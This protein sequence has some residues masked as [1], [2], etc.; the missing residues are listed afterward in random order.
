MKKFLKFKQFIL[1]VA[2]LL[3][4]I[5]LL[6]L[7]FEK[8]DSIT[9]QFISNNVFNSQ[10]T[11]EIRLIIQDQLIKNNVK[12]L[13]KK[14]QIDII[15]NN[16]NAKKFN[17]LLINEFK[18]AKKIKLGY[19]YKFNDSK[20]LFLIISNY[21]CLIDYLEGGIL[22]AKNLGIKNSVLEIAGVN[23][24]PYSY[25]NGY[26]ALEEELK[27]LKKKLSVAEKDFDYLIQ[28]MKDDK[29]LIYTHSF[30]YKFNFKTKILLLVY[31][32]NV[33][34]YILLNL[35]NIKKISKS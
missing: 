5:L 7:F 33:L 31:F 15:E 29:F 16:F 20:N 26:L 11:F 12:F 1:I 10:T 22:L 32:I 30:Y 28:L 34:L 8:K 21:Q 3:S 24:E 2:N 19:C 13:E 14:N 4:I 35:K 25:K 6:F 18:N 27:L 17:N 23:Y 9:I